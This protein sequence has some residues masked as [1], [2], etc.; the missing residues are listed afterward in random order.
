MLDSLSVPRRPYDFEDYIDIL[1]RNMRWIIAPTFA[2][3]VISTVVAYFMT[4]TFFS[5]ALIRVTPQ[6][7]S[8]ELIQ[9]VTSQDVADRI[10]SM[11]QTILSRNTLTNI[12]NQYGLY[13]KELKG[14]PMDDV[15]DTMHKAIF[16]QPSGGVAA[17]GKFL[18][19]MQI[20]F[21]YSDRYVARNVCADL[22]SRFMS[23][24]SQDVAQ[25][26]Q[27]A[28]EFLGSE[29]EAAKRDLD[30]IEEKL[31]DFQTQHAGRLP[32]DMQMNMQ[33][34][35]ALDGRLGSLSEAANRNNEQRM[36]L[37]TELHVAKDRL[38]SIHSPQSLAQNEKVAAL[39]REI[40]ST[41]NNIAA[42]KERYTDD[43]PDLQGAKDQLNFLKRQRDAA[44]KEK[45]S[46]V[47]APIDNPGVMRERLDSQ[48]IIEN[49]QTQMK[50]NAMEAQQ[51]SRDMA[52]VNTAL[53]TYQGRFEGVPA[54]AKEYTDL[55]R[56][57]DLAKARYIEIEMKREKSNT[58]LHME[59][60]KEGE[61]LE[62]I[63]QASLP[64]T[65]FAPKRRTIIPIG[66][67]IGLIVG[68]LLVAVREVKDTSLKNLKDARLYTQLSIL[69]SVPLL[70]N[71]VVVQRRKQVM[72]VGWA[73]ATIA[74][75]AIMAGS[76]ARYYMNR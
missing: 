34:M 5:I 62:L 1:R 2:G 50:A 4:D 72:W 38:A 9:S 26:Q 25:S 66:A 32:D 67:V 3:L 55:L 65:P 53:K 46:K 18:P 8:P 12:I 51:I 27:E 10:N 33:E 63:D 57:R 69:G 22:V 16:I 58:S 74:G 73:T 39:D 13:K 24:S 56:D 64:A 19:A 17:G 45:P 15:I 28:G 31:S 48:A 71:D 43:Y 61:T 35:N 37:E 14:E 30:A 42:M 75:L 68:V 11:A 36:M 23:L 40:E 44:A 52:N 41:E 54:G 60:R 20:G 29:F 49:L 21:F 70:E 7:I 47:D 76:V 59:Q 6:Q